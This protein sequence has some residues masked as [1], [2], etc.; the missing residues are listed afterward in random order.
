MLGGLWTVAAPLLEVAAYA[1][2]FGFLLPSPTRGAGLSY[3]IFIASG[4]LPWAAFREA[5]EASATTLPDHRWIRRSR[6][7]LE[8]LVARL[9]VVAASRALVGLVLVTTLRITRGSL[10]GGR[11]IVVAALTFLAVGPLRLPTVGV[12]LAMAAV[13]LALH[14]TVPAPPTPAAP[15]AGQASPEEIC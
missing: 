12:V 10:R 1:L 14:W 7:P 8:L 11:G 9:V 13:S 2:V 3:A 15:S 5:L 4:L 6:V